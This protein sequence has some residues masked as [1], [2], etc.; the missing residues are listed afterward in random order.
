M[1]NYIARERLKK[2][3][4]DR[5]ENEGGRILV[6]RTRADE[7]NPTSDHEGEGNQLSASHENSTVGAPPLPRTSVEPALNRITAYYDSHTSC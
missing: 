7:S 3:A 1:P 4:L 6:D 2:K 5:W